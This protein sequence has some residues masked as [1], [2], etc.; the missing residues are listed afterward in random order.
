MSGSPLRLLI[1]EDLELVAEAFEALLSTEPAFEVVARVGRGDHVLPAVEKHRPDV[2]LL[3]VDMPGA[4]GIE[5]AR[6]VTAGHPEC[7][8]ILLTAL[9]GSGHLHQGLLA[10]AS[11][12]LV[13][14][15]TGARLIDAIKAVAAG[16]IV[17][18][19]QLAADALRRGPNPLTAREQNILRAVD[20]GLDSRAIAAELF[21]SRGTVRNY[22]STIMTKLDARSRVDAVRVAHHRGWL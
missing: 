1:A 14:A 9:P 12:Y 11:G 19:P 5:A 16:S 3:D 2:A 6:L 21:L 10:G 15:T 7:R 18:D 8:V 20:R 4:T 17:I 13:K 22:L